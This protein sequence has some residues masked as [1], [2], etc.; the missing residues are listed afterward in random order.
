MY[1][2]AAAEEL[3]TRAIIS[4]VTMP[5]SGNRTIP[6]DGS[7]RRITSAV[8]V[9]AVSTSAKLYSVDAQCLMLVDDEAPSAVAER[10]LQLGPCGLC[11]PRHKGLR[12]AV[13]PRRCQSCSDNGMLMLSLT[14]L[15][16]VEI[17]STILP[18]AIS[19][20]DADNRSQ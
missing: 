14:S 4:S 3:R 16:R 18:T 5:L 1:F 6:E 10:Q 20:V 12:P 17:P 7:T 9:I 19:S 8:R 15:S 2:G 13:P 11:R